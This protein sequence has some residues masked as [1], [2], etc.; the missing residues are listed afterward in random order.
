MYEN[1]QGQI[2]NEGIWFT[3]MSALRTILIQKYA[4]E[5]KIPIL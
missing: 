3:H 4:K 5:E 1:F 2:K